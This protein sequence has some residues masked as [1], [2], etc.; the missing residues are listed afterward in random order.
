VPEEYSREQ[1]EAALA[2]AGISKLQEV[3]SLA[4]YNGN[5]Y[6]GEDL[7]LD[8]SRGCYEWEDLRQHLEHQGVTPNS[9]YRL[10][11]S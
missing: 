3:G 1:I 2:A 7:V 6:P 8:W 10:L 9:V 5:F 4:V 11:C